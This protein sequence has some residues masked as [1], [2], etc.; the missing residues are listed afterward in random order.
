MRKRWGITWEFCLGD[1][2]LGV[3]FK[4]T[5]YMGGV[6]QEGGHLSDEG[7]FVWDVYVVFIPTL[8][9]HFWFPGKRAKDIFRKRLL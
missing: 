2:W 6:Y 3:Y 1:W 9:I 5:F 4:R 7:E 8:P